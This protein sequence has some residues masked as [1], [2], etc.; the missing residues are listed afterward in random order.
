[1]NLSRRNLG[2][3][4]AH[5]KLR[6]A[7][8][9]VALMLLLPAAVQAA[10]QVI[11]ISSE[12]MEAIY[13]N[14]TNEGKRPPTANTFL[15]SKENTVTITSGGNV[16]G[17]VYGGYYYHPGGVTTDGANQTLSTTNQVL[18]T[19]G[20]EVDA[21]AS[22]VYGGYV[23]LY[24]ILGRVVPSST[25]NWVDVEAASEVTA[26]ITAA[27]IYG[28][29]AEANGTTHTAEAK[30]NYVTAT[31]VTAQVTATS[32]IYGGSVANSAGGAL[33]VLISST[34]NHVQA[35][36]SGKVTATSG[37]IYGGYANKVAYSSSI[38]ADDN[39]VEA[40]SGGE[41]TAGR[42]IYGGYAWLDYW[43]DISTGCPSNCLFRVEEN[44]VKATGENSMVKASGNIY[45]GYAYQ[46]YSMLL[47]SDPSRTLTVEGN[48]VEAANGGSV[49]ATGNIY[50]GHA[51]FNNDYSRSNRETV[52]AKGNVVTVTGENS[53]MSAVDIYGGYAVQP[54]NSDY[55]S[56][57]VSVTAEGNRVEATNSGA[58]TVSGNIYGG[59]A[60]SERTDAIAPVTAKENIVTVT[61]EN[62]SMGAVDNIYG[63]YAYAAGANAPA[64]A[65]ENQ[66]RLEGKE[67]VS[68]NVFG[69]FARASRA[70]STAINNAITIGGDVSGL[71]LTSTTLYGGF[72]GN[73]LNTPTSGANAFTGNILKKNSEVSVSAVRNFQT[74]EFGYSGQ[75]NISAF[76]TTPTSYLNDADLNV[77]LN[78]A[79]THTITF[80]GT[81]SGDASLTKTG[82]G[83]LILT[84][85][86]GT[87]SAI[88]LDTGKLYFTG[89]GAV[90]GSN[91]FARLTVG[92]NTTLGLKASDGTTLIAANPT[93]TATDVT[94]G[95][96]NTA[97]D[98]LGD[99]VWD[100]DYLLI[101]STNAINAN[102]SKFFLNGVE[103]GNDFNP[104]V[105]GSY[106][107]V[108]PRL[109][110]KQ[111]WI[112]GGL[113][114][115]RNDANAHGTFNMAA[116]DSYTVTGLVDNANV[117]P[118]G[119]ITSDYSWNGQDLTKS[120]ADTSELILA[121][122]NSY[123]GTTTITSGTLKVTG[124]LD[125]DATDAF[126]YDKAISIGA[127]ALLTFANTDGVKQTL[128]GVISSTDTTGSLV[129]SGN[130]I[131][132]LSG[133]N[134][135]TTGTTISGGEVVVGNDRALGGSGGTAGQV[136]MAGGTTLS[137]SDGY[138]VTNAFTLDGT[139][140]FD[141][142]AY[143]ATL[144]GVIG[145]SSGVLTKTGSG[146][147]IL[148]GENSYA[149]G[150]A[151]NK[152]I[153]KVGTDTALDAT[154]VD[155]GRVTMAD[156][157]ALEFGADALSVANYFTLAGTATFNTGTYTA[158]L[159]GVIGGSSG[160]TG[161]LTKTG[162]GTL[163]LNGENSYAAGTALNEGI[164][165]VG[166][167]TALGATSVDYG[168]VTMADATA[169]EFGTNALSVAN[170]FTLAGTATFDTGAHT[171]TL[172]GV[173]GGNDTSSLTKTGTGTLTLGA[174][175]TGY[176]GSLAFGADGGTIKLDTNAALGMLDTGT[177]IYS[178]VGAI[179]FASSGT[180]K[181]TLLFNQD[182]DQTLTGAITGAGTLTKQADNT[183]TL[184]NFTGFTGT[185]EVK[186]GIV[187]LS[188]DMDLTG[189]NAFN[190]TLAA[191]DTTGTLSFD[192]GEKNVDGKVT[193][194]H[195]LEF[196]TSV[197]GS[198]K[199]TIDLMGGTTLDLDPANVGAVLGTSSETT[200]QLSADG[201]A[202]AGDTGTET[203]I[204]ALTFNGGILSL[205]KAFNSLDD[206]ILT[207]DTLGM[208]GE[209]GSIR[210]DFDAAAITTPPQPGE[211]NFF[212][213]DDVSTTSEYQKLLV[214]ADEV[215]DGL[216]GQRLSLLDENNV[217][218]ATGAEITR[219]IKG[220]TPDDTPVGKAKFDYVA[221]IV[222]KDDTTR[223]K[224]VYLGYGLKEIIA[225]ETKIVTLDAS[226]SDGQLS[227]YAKLTET[228][229]DD[230]TQGG[231]TF[232]GNQM[233]T[234][235]QNASVGNSESNYTG[236]TTVNRLALTATANKAFGETSN[237]ILTNEASVTFGSNVSLIVGGLNTTDTETSVNLG[238]GTLTVGVKDDDVRTGAGTFAGSITGAGMLTKDG[239]GIFTLT[240]SLASGL[241]VDA[242]TFTVSG[243]GGLF[244]DETFSSRSYEKPIT[245]ATN[246]VLEFNQAAG[247]VQTLTGALTGA[248]TGGGTLIQNAADPTA[249]LI[250]NN[251]GNEIGLVEVSNGKLIVG[252]QADDN[253]NA[254]LTAN[255]N[256]R[257]SADAPATLGGHGTV[258]GEVNIGDYGVL[259]PGN[260]IGH[261]V[262]GTLSFDKNLT[263]DDI[264][265]KF[266]PIFFS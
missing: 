56:G 93:L 137:F 66:V 120:G 111:L 151:L 210:L 97:L 130:S 194:T 134:T 191:G 50:G 17:A 41:V 147:L 31:G 7:A 218:V 28:G 258:V 184:K 91:A 179:T 20:G 167:D 104:A 131:L 165:K 39:H 196:G 145:G 222:E 155:Y 60:R 14:G 235:I 187:R 35:I 22:N 55:T 173:I 88:M 84:Q 132:V 250:L 103:R 6:A 10:G 253:S 209:G 75:A 67:T 201:E 215:K 13:G 199:G 174:K 58:M 185:Y 32:N 230:T 16:K 245:L 40:E 44:R 4:F 244:S 121:G 77:Y 220:T 225:Y 43:G 102:F 265:P 228:N 36:D 74:I 164:I 19:S 172:D 114:W 193:T 149:A 168:R 112:K 86:L 122:A 169:L 221:F 68:G 105:T 229:P 42:D 150:T 263:T 142:G 148:N 240:G 233:S 108:D 171:A 1:L 204:Q 257:G 21:G 53:S 11:T 94:I 231:F 27:N 52:T 202:T 12:V 85:A 126:L 234:N 59:Y 9:A 163:I 87:T 34:G 261:L 188:K 141:T 208:T 47:T 30:D 217:T 61:G 192:L 46:D 242:G 127:G 246:S 51:Q 65:D 70:G 161:V 124:T 54:P 110:E 207:V 78:V 146:T 153:I 198:F 57:N 116:G 29:Y 170:Y 186:D 63:G 177:G 98:V 100:T 260:S 195:A 175:S 24:T 254:K 128:S 251:V 162:T 206:N 129:K 71:T 49:S 37:D 214:K 81:I 160:T 64:K 249:K 95:S 248:F 23:Y 259:S 266:Q 200:L 106:L 255:V 80:G 2:V 115:Y 119:G 144:G 62:S 38:I 135:Y 79:D 236:S 89:T 211:I 18:V 216:N 180:D 143:T 166:T 181:G 69:G 152:G 133:T 25:G 178:Y 182:A 252:G 239:A 262:T 138:T 90:N 213:S 238:S 158:T 136:S 123:S 241:K 83:K 5:A 190:N 125:S 264:K 226:T 96:T 26:T 159:D 48:H 8:L 101:Q 118:G 15:P 219:E 92:D 113:T 154:S 189:T 72:V 224:G 45:G 223:D 205:P 227:I 232:M 117:A 197:S 107:Y 73:A 33:N 109:E 243:T 247:I 156:T 183:V 237:L 212:D 176:S 76:N 99:L 140:T 139:A 256:V 157:T 203:T 3:R 82:A